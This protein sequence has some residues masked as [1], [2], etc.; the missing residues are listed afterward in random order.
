MCEHY[1]WFSLRGYSIRTTDPSLE[2][3]F[4]EIF[5]SE[6]LRFWPL[7]VSKAEGVGNFMERTLP[8][9]LETQ[10]TGW[11][12]FLT[13]ITPLSPWILVEWR[14]K[15]WCLSREGRM[16]NAGDPSMRVAGMQIPQKP[17]WRLLSSDF[18]NGDDTPPPGGVFPVFLPMDTIAGFLG[19]FEKESWF[20]EVRE[21]FMERRGG[22][23]LFRLRLSYGKQEFVVLVQRSKYEGVEF[24]AALKD[25]L[26]RLAKEGGNHLI[27]ATY[28]GKIVVSNLS[29]GAV[30]G[31]GSSR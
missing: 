8:V 4:W 27:D 7:W 28:E 30:A 2:R 3:R 12:S 13:R 17:L 16:W 19:E 10:M 24:A 23:E 14:E 5:P 6:C 21:I 22:A 11:G 18:L 31:E 25:V 26:D 9:S 20:G 29:S 1:V 15:V